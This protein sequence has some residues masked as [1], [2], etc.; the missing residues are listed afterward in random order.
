MMPLSHRLTFRQSL[1][2][3]AHLVKA[4]MRQRF[5]ELRP[6]LKQHI[7]ADAVVID[8]GAH[9]GEFT[10]IFSALAPQGQVYSFEPGSYAR[11]IL[12]RVV[13]M[14]GLQNVSIEPVGLGDKIS[15]D[16][17]RLP[18]KS[19]GS[20][21]FGLSHLGDDKTV[22]ARETV[23]EKVDLV[24]LDDFVA[25]KN[26]SRIDFIKIDV[27]GWELRALE[28]GRKTIEKFHPVL[29]LEMVDKFLGRAGDSS[30]KLW[31]FLKSEG[32]DVYRY[33]ETGRT[34]FLEAPV[35]QGD[36]ICIRKK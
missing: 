1:T 30:R 19:S 17:L 36:I 14:R 15:S 24:T 33:D 21:G 5:L 35:E 20:I 22:D 28:G 31:D 2:Y 25:R 3:A 27:E 7:P 8:V 29:M 11:S 18:L 16:T 4:L 13:R 23:E 10:K 9:A 12:S 6:L 32:Y 34:D 26:L